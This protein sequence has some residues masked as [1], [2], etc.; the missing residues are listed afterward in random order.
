MHQPQLRRRLADWQWPSSL[1]RLHAVK[2]DHYITLG[3][4]RDCTSEQLRA[5]YRS[6]TKQFHPDLNPNSGAALRI[7]QELNTAYK[8][9]SDP[10]R[11]QDYD[12]TLGAPEKPDSRDR[13]TKHDPPL[14]REVHLRLKELIH[15]TSLEVRIDHPALSD[16][17]ELYPV[18]IPPGT[19]PGARIRIPR[20]PPFSGSFVLIRIRMLPDFRFKVRGSDLRCDLKISTQRAVHGGTE[21]IPGIA[22]TSLRV[23]I[24]PRVGRGEIVRLPG[25][26]LP[27]PRG[28]R[29]DLLVRLI[30][31]PEIRITR[32]P[33][34]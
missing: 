34:R 23:Q 14:S 18:A 30:Y 20:S 1:C 27:K 19:A 15:G 31:R 13:K 12:H 4:P 25:E 29:G 8:I 24:P 21:M 6:L 11:R 17:P 16:G 32:K 5:A 22:G 7:S 2:P 3:L 28:G 10:L 33:G 9:L 26:G